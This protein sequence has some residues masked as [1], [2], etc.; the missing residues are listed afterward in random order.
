MAE[1]YFNQFPTVKYNDTTCRDITRRVKINEETRQALTLYYTYEVKDGTRPDLI[2]QAYYEDPELDW[3]LWLTNYIIDP[4]YQWSLSNHDFEDYV[5]KKYGSIEASIKKIAYYRNNWY[6]DEITITPEFYENNLERGWKKYYAPFYGHGVKILYWMRREED[7]LMET[8][9]I[10][11][12]TMANTAPFIKGE[13]VD[14]ENETAVTR[15]GGGE[16]T[17]VSNTYIMIKNIDGSFAN[18]YIVTGEVSNLPQTITDT[19]LV[20]QAIT[21]DEAI[22]WSPVTYYDTENEKNAYARTINI[23]D[24]SQLIPTIDQLQ[25][26]IKA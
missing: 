4:Y 21:D 20:Y 18:N 15:R 7:W 17:A 8:N 12:L 13:L 6:N 9:Q 25:T 26:L 24:R 11:K 2:A 10:W 19:D 23:L 3:M 1:S 5:I 14:V 22:F 16:V